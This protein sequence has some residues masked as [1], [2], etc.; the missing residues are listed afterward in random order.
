MIKHLTAFSLVAVSLAFAAPA[1][2]NTCVQLDPARD[3]LAEGDRTGAVVM[4][5]QTLARMGRQV[6]R[7]NCQETF[8][9]YHVRLGASVN[10]YLQGP[11]GVREG[12][13]SRIEE[14]PQVYDQMVRSLLTGVAMN[15]ATNTV[16]R[17]NVTHNQQAPRRV[18][19]DSLWYARLGY[20]AVAGAGGAGGPAFGFG[21]RFELDS[22]GIDASFLNLVWD[23]PETNSTTGNTSGG[24]I[25]GSWVKLMALYYFDPIANGSLY[26]GG[27][28]SWGG[29]A[30]SDGNYLY[31]GS[32][33]QGELAGGYEF[34]RASSIR[35]FFEVAA[36]LP[37]YMVDRDDFG[38]TGGDSAY[39]PIFTAS[40]GLGWGRGLNRVMVIQ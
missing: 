27:G 21:Y 35:I 9:V 23:S 14:L 17:E 32:G 3:T 29:T 22:L 8:H 5:E 34:L 26:A 30:T 20:G 7:D 19:A 28:V 37:F 24:G 33:L 15:T 12:Q 16:N 1:S 18:E 13:A 36:T 38:A 4:L 2:A 31:S 40:I 10:V 25:N 11:Q 6:G 39:A